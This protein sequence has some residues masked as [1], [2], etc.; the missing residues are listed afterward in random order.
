LCF[1]G[2]AQEVA[3]LPG[4]Y[5][6][7]GGCLLLAWRDG[8]PVGCVAMRPL[9]ARTCEMK[10]MY[11]RES[12]RGD[13]LGRELALR[14]IAEAR[15]A[16]YM[17]MVLDTLPQMDSAIRLYESLDFRRRDAYYKTPLAETV[18]MKLRLQ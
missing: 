5:A 8:I 11:V 15:H 12:A 10:R 2:F 3:E 7:P 13:G 6:S 14:A 16:G 4:C 9:D 18:F 1:Q 17:A